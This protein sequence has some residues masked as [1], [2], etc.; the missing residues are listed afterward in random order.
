MY[1]FK[2]NVI[3]D[4]IESIDDWL[5]FGT[6]QFSR[7]TS[8][9]FVIDIFFVLIRSIE[10]KS[11]S[12]WLLKVEGDNIT[13][14]IH[15]HFIV[16]S[17]GLRTTC[18]KSNLF[19][20]NPIFSALKFKYLSLNKASVKFEEYDK[21]KAGAFYLSKI[22]VGVL[23]RAP[24]YFDYVDDGICVKLSGKLKRRYKDFNLNRPPLF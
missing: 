8:Y 1:L 22:E 9:K 2:E 6:V 14:N 10:K 19:K 23:N 18:A 3:T 5:I 17:D 21:Q 16:S 12:V 11:G 4:I 20:L 15:I 13:R 24:S 7:T